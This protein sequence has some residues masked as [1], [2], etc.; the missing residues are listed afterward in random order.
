MAQKIPARFIPALQYLVHQLVAGNYTVL[1]A[2]GRL[3]T[4]GL[5]AELLARAITEHGRT[6]IEMPDDAIENESAYA[7]GDGDWQINLD[8]WTD[9]EEDQFTLSVLLRDKPDGI[10]A[11]IVDL[12]VL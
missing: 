11:E 3:G 1:E 4:H 8:L 5:T 7:Q 9:D 12:D 6:L 2:E 10:W